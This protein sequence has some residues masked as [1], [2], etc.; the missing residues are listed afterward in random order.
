MQRYN[1]L[2]RGVEKEFVPALKR[3]GLGMLPYYPL[4]SGF[5][6]GKYRPGEPPPEGTRLASGIRFYVGV[7]NERNFSA[8][9]KLEEFARERGHTMIELAI[10]WLATQPF[11]GSVIC[12]ATRS[13]QVEENANSSEWR[14]SGDDLAELEMI[15]ATF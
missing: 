15:L 2:E 3:L 10:G 14:L 11:M 5:L 9:G 1:L 13:E 4:A 12:G 6:T 7:L 8:L